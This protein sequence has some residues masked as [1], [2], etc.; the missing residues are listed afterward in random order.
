VAAG[1][2][3]TM[4]ADVGITIDDAGNRTS[5]DGGRTRP[6]ALREKTK[7]AAKKLRDY[8]RQDTLVADTRKMPDSIYSAVII[9]WLQLDTVFECIT[10][11]AVIA[12]FGFVVALQG[13]MALYLFVAIDDAAGDLSDNCGDTSALLR[14]GCTI[15]FCSMIVKDVFESMGMGIWLG[16]FHWSL[17][18]FDALRI[19]NLEI[20]TGTTGNENA[21]NVGSTNI[22][23]PADDYSIGLPSL[24][25]AAVV[26]L[27]KLFIALIVLLAGGGGVMRSGNNFDLCLNTLAA[28]FLLDIDNQLYTLLIPAYTRKHHCTVPEIAMEGDN[29]ERLIFKLFKVFPAIQMGV[30][31]G[32][33]IIICILVIYFWCESDPV[34]PGL[35][36]EWRN[37]FIVSWLRFAVEYGEQGFE[38]VTNVTGDFVDEYYSGPD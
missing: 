38:G 37:D 35:K 36:R 29:A 1:T 4:P 6:A 32:M 9:Y 12:L 25:L 16:A 30:M 19:D 13:V 26:I 10:F 15:L 21:V 22:A 5:Q 24:M 14:W 8:A 34:I 28:T 31:F 11:V 7:S 27:L 20:T 23:R 3:K 33:V 17:I 18:S 2:L